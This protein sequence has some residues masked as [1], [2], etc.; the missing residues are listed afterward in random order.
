MT[1]VQFFYIIFFFLLS[2]VSHHLM[3]PLVLGA[4]NS[5]LN[6]HGYFVFL[7]VSFLVSMHLPFFL[8]RALLPPSSHVRTTSAF[9]LSSSFTLVPLLLM[10]SHVHSWSYCS[11]TYPPQHPYFINL[12]SDPLII[13]II[14]I[15][16]GMAVFFTWLAT[17]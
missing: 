17:S 8:A 5:K 10:L 15:M 9:Y 11:S 4:I 2:G 13:I 16:A 12:Q 14:L 1:V 3:S 6:R 7:S